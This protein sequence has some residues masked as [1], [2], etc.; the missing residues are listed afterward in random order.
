MILSDVMADT[1]VVERMQNEEG[2]DIGKMQTMCW[3]MRYVGSLAGLA[4]S[5][6]CLSIFSL[7]YH[8]MFACLGIAHLFM[9]LPSLIMLKDFAIDTSS[10]ASNREDTGFSN[11]LWK[12]W[13]AIQ[14]TH[15]FFP[16]IF[17]FIVAAMPVSSLYKMF[18]P[19]ASISNI[20]LIRYVCPIVLL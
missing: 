3:I 10:D 5:S 20:H 14:M 15:I 4:G 18:P 1:L 6:I 13:D 12:V 19:F 11:M 9:M 16:M 2:N 17:I 8:T 7:K